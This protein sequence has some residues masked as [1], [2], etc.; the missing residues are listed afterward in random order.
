MISPKFVLPFI[1]VL[2]AL[3][4]NRALAEFE[5]ANDT[6]YKASDALIQV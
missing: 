5:D 3:F 1:K 6:F 2:A 4:P